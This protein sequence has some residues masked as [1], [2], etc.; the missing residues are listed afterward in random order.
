MNALEEKRLLAATER[1]SWALRRIAYALETMVTAS[2]VARVSR[3]CSRCGSVLR[4]PS[5]MSCPICSDEPESA[6]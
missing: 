6:P 2:D 3:A 4:K 1:G 5:V